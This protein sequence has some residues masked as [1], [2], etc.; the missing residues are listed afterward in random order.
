MTRAELEQIAREAAAQYNLP[1][2]VF[3]RLIQQESGFDPAAVSRKGAIGPAQLM[4]DTAKE[5]G[6][7]PNNVRENIFGGAKYLSQQLSRFGEMPLALA[8]YNAGPTRVARLGRIPNIPETQNY[9]KN[10]LGSTDGQ[11]LSATRNNTMVGNIQTPPIFPQQQQ[12]QG[13]LRGLLSS[14]MQP[15]QTTGLTGPENF[16]QA[17][18]ALILPEA[19]MGEQIRARGAQRL[20]QGSRNETIKQLERMAKNGDPLATELLAAVK[21]RAISP[22]DAYKTLLAQKYDTKGDTIRSSV[23]FKNGAYYVITDKGRK[24]YDTQ[25]NLVPDGPKA[26]EV[27][28]EAELSGIAM[29]G[30]GAGAV[31]QAQ[32]QQKYADELFGKASQITENIATIDE[33]IQQIDAGARRGPVLDFLPNITPASSALETALTRMGLDV[34][35]TV[36]FGALSEA[37]MRAA[38]ATAYPQN[39]NEQDLRQWLVDRKNGLQKL[40]KYSEEAATFLSNPMNTRADWVTRMQERRDQQNAASQENPYMSMT[41]PQLNVEFTKYN[42]MT[43]TQKA[44]FTAALRAKQR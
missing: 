32:F 14:F 27:L 44:Q 17:L 23:K 10:I 12:R 9:V 5:L 35:S 25:G 30:Y 15:N 38:M 22:A 36:T 39:L 18:D 29:E 11:P 24:V 28:R 16:A 7:N 3:L 40:R 19:R 37:E 1:V 34:I 2:D 33:A 41:V 42:E 31:E 21:S 8:A 6:V 43:E 20:A 13:G 4:P 26:A